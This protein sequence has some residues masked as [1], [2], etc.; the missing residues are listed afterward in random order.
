MRQLP[1]SILCL[2]LILMTSCSDQEAP[3]LSKTLTIKSQADIDIYCDQYTRWQSTIVVECNQELNY[4]CIE[5]I[6]ETND[7]SVSGSSVSKALQ[8]L[9]EV[10]NHGGYGL[11]ISDTDD[12][13]LSLPNL[14]I[15]NNIA[16]FGTNNFR[17]IEAPKVVEAE[18]LILAPLCLSLE[19]LTG[20]HKVKNLEMLM[21]YVLGGQEVAIDAFQELETIDLLTL[22]IEDGSLKLENNSLDNIREI[23]NYLSIT[24]EAGDFDISPLISRL[25]VLNKVHLYGNISKQQICLFERF[26]D[27]EE[28]ELEVNFEHWTK[29]R[30]DTFCE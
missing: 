4:T 15:V 26:Y 5:P 7:V 3:Q 29:E 25:E 11:S 17:F 16:L 13:T 8:Y 20:F 9:E 30:F 18:K 12:E 2:T 10:G 14:R 24:D 23:S 1:I 28:F 19:R 27:K 6:K 21:V 22:R